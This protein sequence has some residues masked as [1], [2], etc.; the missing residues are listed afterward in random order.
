[1]DSQVLRE[2]REQLKHE[3]HSYN[4]IIG[5][6]KNKLIQINKYIHE[7]MILL[8]NYI[9]DTICETRFEPVYCFSKIECIK[10]LRQE[11][12][13]IE[14]SLSLKCQEREKLEYNLKGINDILCLR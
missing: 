6:E 7:N 5:K 1:M 13:V 12:S 11:K 3:I 9:I 14:K 2:R 10:R 8:C 4:Y